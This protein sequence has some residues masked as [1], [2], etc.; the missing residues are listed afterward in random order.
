MLAIVFPH[1]ESMA[2]SPLTPD[3]AWA[4]IAAL[5]QRND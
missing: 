1:D 2:L 4:L 3:E 5:E